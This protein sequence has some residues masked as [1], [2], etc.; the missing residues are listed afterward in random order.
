MKT[1]RLPYKLFI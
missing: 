1:P